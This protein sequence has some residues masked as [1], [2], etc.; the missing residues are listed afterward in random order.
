MLTS[1][2]CNFKSSLAIYKSKWKKFTENFN[3]VFIIFSCFNNAILLHRAWSNTIHPILMH[4]NVNSSRYL[5]FCRTTVGNSQSYHGSNLQD[6]FFKLLNAVEKLDL[7]SIV[8][9]QAQVKQTILIWSQ[10]PF[11]VDRF[12][13]KTDCCYDFIKVRYYF[14]HYYYIAHG[15]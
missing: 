11:R 15:R 12:V 14:T 10:V 1:R 9:F 6:L 8:Y 5:I 2:T 4:S 13:Q 7:I 3:L